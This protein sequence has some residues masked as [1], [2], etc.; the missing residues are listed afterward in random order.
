[1][2]INN[3]FISTLAVMLLMALIPKSALAEAR[4]SLKIEFSG[5]AKSLSVIT[6]T[7]GLNPEL[8]DARSRRSEADEKAFDSLERIRLKI[9]ALYQATEHIRVGAKVDYDHQAHFGGF[10]GSGDFR[11][12]K[13]QL[14]DRQFSDL[15]QTFVEEDNAFYE[16][17]LY[18]ASL[19]LETKYFDLEIGRQQIPWG[20]G[21]FF[22]ANRPL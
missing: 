1:M 13:K 20:G 3:R 6:A 10:V 19:T 2:S 17:R 9:R 4:P 15:S 14:E 8:V 21:S 7:S 11:I 18:R 12:A 16:H 22:Y 5:Y